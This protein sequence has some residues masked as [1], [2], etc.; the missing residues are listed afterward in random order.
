MKCYNC[1]KNEADNR[2]LVNYMGHAGEVHL[3]SEC[4]E[5]FRQ[6]ASSILKEV[7]EKGFTQPY[8][9][10]NFEL[11]ASRDAGGGRN[12]PVDAGEKIKRFRRLGEL[13]ESLKAAV[14]IEDFETAA[15]IRDE[16][17]RIEKEV[18]V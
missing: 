1:S 11:S 14:E 10:P 6:Y 18:C 13:R 16:I 5:S 12:F 15:V 4:L 8:A 2:L 17:Y 3:C 9:W 7:R